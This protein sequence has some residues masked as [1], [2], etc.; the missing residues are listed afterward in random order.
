[1]PPACR[2]STAKLHLSCRA[3]ASCKDGKRV[4]PRPVYVSRLPRAPLR[5]AAKRPLRR[6]SARFRASSPLRAAASPAPSSRRPPRRA[7]GCNDGRSADTRARRV[8][9]FID[10]PGVAAAAVDVI[11]LDDGDDAR[12]R[13]VE[14]SPGDDFIT[15]RGVEI[16]DL[17]HVP[18]AGAGVAGEPRSRRQ[19]PARQHVGERL[20]RQALPRRGI[21]TQTAQ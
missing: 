14:Q 15:G 19:Q 21:E 17:R 10:A 11:V 13:Q 7:A 20:A 18:A 9:R 8:E 5:V 6:R 12:L 4:S 3:R 1:M 16:F 2:V